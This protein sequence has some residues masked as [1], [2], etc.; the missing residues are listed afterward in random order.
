MK[1]IFLLVAMVLCLQT[2]FAAQKALAA[3]G[4][5]RLCARLLSRIGLPVIGF[6]LKQ[7]L[8]KT[9]TA[10]ARSELS[11]EFPIPESIE[12]AIKAGLLTT[13]KFLPVRITGRANSERV[14]IQFGARI[15]S[16]E[17]GDGIEA[18]F[19]DPRFPMAITYT[20]YTLYGETFRFYVGRHGDAKRR[21]I[22][23]VYQPVGYSGDFSEGFQI[24]HGKE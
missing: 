8:I 19:E 23:V 22:S 10:T 7:L 18:H 16:R 15:F 6:G 12:Q 2:T 14:V 21:S 1:N 20:V 4:E 17:N 5:P 24:A 3:R 11:G 13:N 9:F